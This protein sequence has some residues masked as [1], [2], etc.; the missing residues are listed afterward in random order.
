MARGL[1]LSTIFSKLNRRNKMQEQ[2]L[3]NPQVDWVALESQALGMTSVEI[4][5]TLHDI[6]QTCNSADDLDYSD[7]GT[8]G[9]YYR[10]QASVYRMELERRK[11]EPVTILSNALRAVIEDSEISEWLMKND[12]EALDRARQA[13]RKFGG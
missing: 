8:R 3:K 12:P 1:K 4:H 11:V 10:D 7:G 5:A 13:L 2:D 9:R 6:V